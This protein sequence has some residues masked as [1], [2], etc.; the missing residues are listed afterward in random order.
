MIVRLP[1]AYPTRCRAVI[2]NGV[3][4][5]FA[6]APNLDPSTYDQTKAA[7]AVVDKTLAEVGS[8]KDRILTATVFIA[9]MAQKDEMNRAWDECTD[10]RLRRRR[11]NRRLP[12]GNAVHGCRSVAPAI[13]MESGL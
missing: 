7:L 12:R 9:D 3:A 11:L 13:S 5:F 8:S 2:H 1:G 4:S 6:V 10:A